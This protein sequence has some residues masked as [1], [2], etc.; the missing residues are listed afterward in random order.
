[1]V[2]G[3]VT[4][5][6]SGRRL[7]GGVPKLEVEV[8]GRPL[9]I[10]TLEAFQLAGSIE[11][12]IVTV[13]PERL[14]HWTA[15]RLRQEGIDKAMATVAGGATRQE[16]VYLA[17]EEIP[18]GVGTVVVHDGARPLVTPELIDAVSVVPGG[19]DGVIT[20]VAVSD[21]VKE[22]ES[23]L[24]MGT[25]DRERLI[26][27]QTPQAFPL[28]VLRKAHRRA[29]KDRFR[30]TDDAILVERLGGKVMVVE[31][32]RENIKVTFPEDLERARSI[33]IARRGQ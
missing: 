27:V 4:A 28:E 17:L 3:I 22:V 7:G 11:Q 12:I 8:L 1:V 14:A 19:V 25:V 30:G 6:G 21:T 26:A 10:H 29:L 13:P 18:H 20:A 32:S 23:G 24:V 31:G 16:S 2:I 33:L 5:G 9:L 15:A